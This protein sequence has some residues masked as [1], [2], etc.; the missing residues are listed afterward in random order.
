MADTQTATTPDNTPKGPTF[1]G[2][3]FLPDADMVYDQR[4]TIKGSPED[5]WPWIVQWGKGRGG[6]YVPAKL[7]KVLP[8]KFRSA[9]VINPEWQS[10]RVG[11]KVADF[12]GAKSKKGSKSNKAAESYLEVA[13]IDNQRALVYKGERM[14]TAFTWA[15]L[16]EDAD[17]N[18]V[19][20]DNSSAS[21]TILHIRFRGQSPQSGWK[22]K[23]AVQVGK[24]ADGLIASAIFPG[25]VDRV[26]HQD[27]KQS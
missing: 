18:P 23:V 8:E 21:E 4:R 7:E 15:L 25:I 10:L 3:E 22:S 17:G 2:D 5:V 26:E 16:L 6:W 19:G 27:K 13:V 14:G 24:V 9:P 12:A 1:T 20:P 11:D